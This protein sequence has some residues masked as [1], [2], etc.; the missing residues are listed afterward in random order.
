MNILDLRVAIQATLSSVLGT[1]HLPNNATTP[2]IA[3]RA[4]GEAL[5]A[6]TRV[7]GIEVVIIRDPEPQVIRQYRQE[8]SINAWTLFLV[9]WG[10]THSLQNAAGRL[11]WA[12]PGSKAIN[13]VVPQG[14]GP[15][16]QIRVD[17]QTNPNFT[18][19]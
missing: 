4:W 10:G 2:A 13:V 12:W 19:T 6:G 1:Y 9:D 17:L 8:V 14:V 11:I 7:T 16:S 15:R 5:P 18:A 3:V